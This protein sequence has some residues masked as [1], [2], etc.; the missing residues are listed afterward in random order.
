LTLTSNNAN[1]SC[2]SKWKPSRKNWA[3]PQMSRN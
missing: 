1:T 3:E 2:T